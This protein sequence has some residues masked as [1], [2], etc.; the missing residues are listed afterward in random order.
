MTMQRKTKILAFGDSHLDAIRFGY[1][2]TLSEEPLPISIHFIRLGSTAG[3]NELLERVAAESNF[4]AMVC[5]LDGNTYFVHGALNS[6]RPF[7]FHLPDAPHLPSSPNAEVIPYDL[8]RNRF[9]S[10]L[11]PCMSIVGAVKS[12]TEVPIYQISPPPPVGNP[13]AIATHIP[14][15]WANE[16]ATC[17]VAPPVLR[18]KLWRVH[19]DVMREL[20]NEFLVP[21]IEAP[22]VAMDDGHYLREDYRWDGFHANPTYG[23]LVIRQ[24]MELPHF[25]SD[26]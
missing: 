16:L 12:R 2:K 26:G 23:Q 8:V 22:A 19:L 20:S 24:L 6:P 10:D 13:D 25:S 21:F 14:K 3:I 7:D 11:R 15:E 4:D 5:S 17:G 1:E 18:Y 9:L